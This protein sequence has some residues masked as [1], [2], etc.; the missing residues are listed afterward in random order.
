MF[1]DAVVTETEPA[2]DIAKAWITD[3]T[4]TVLRVRLNHAACVEYTDSFDEQKSA[5]LIDNPSMLEYVSDPAYYY[6]AGTAEGREASNIDQIRR[7]NK[8]EQIV[9]APEAHDIIEFLNGIT[10]VVVDNDDDSSGSKLRDPRLGN[11]IPVAN[12]SMGTKSVVLLKTLLSDGTLQPGTFLIL[13]EP[14]IHLHPQWQLKYAEALVLL[15]K[16]M[17]VHVLVTT[18]SPYFL[19][20]L[21]VYAQK[22]SVADKHHVYSAEGHKNGTVSFYEVK[23]QEKWEEL[24]ETMIS[25]FDDIEGTEFRLNEG[26]EDAIE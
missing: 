16:K 8:R 3:K 17:N 11:Q 12:G 13:D 9:V 4:R 7:R 22:Y 18:H 1:A 5:I 6:T 25:P 20:A 15:M 24:Y 23:G 14:E 19:K 2:Q 10:P 21:R 26:L